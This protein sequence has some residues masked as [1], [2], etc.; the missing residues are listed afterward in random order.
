MAAGMQDY[1][2]I[3]RPRYGAAK[4]LAETKPAV[5]LDEVSIGDVSGRGMIYGGAI[6]VSPLTTQRNSEPILEVDG[7]RLASANFFTLNYFNY[8]KE[9]I[10]A[11]YLMCYDDTNF[12]YILGVA[13]GLTF[14]KGFEVLYNEAHNKTPAVICEVYYALI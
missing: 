5:A 10:S 11:L 13:P 12:I 2:K 6:K 1:Q 7:T 3:I 8:T 4:V 9:H 14:E